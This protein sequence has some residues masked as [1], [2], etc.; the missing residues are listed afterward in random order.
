MPDT[1]VLRVKKP[2]MTGYSAFFP[3][4]IVIFVTYN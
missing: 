3:Y 4:G 2:T 1:M